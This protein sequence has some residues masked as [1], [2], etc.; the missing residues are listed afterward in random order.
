MTQARTIYVE[1]LPEEV[2][3][4]T[5]I[6]KRIE[7]CLLDTQLVELVKLRVSQIN[8]CSFCVAY[9]STRLRLMD[10]T[11]ER[12][13]QLSVWRESPQF[14]KREQTALQWAEELTRL[15]DC[16]GVSDQRYATTVKEFGDEGI[17]QLTLAVAMINLWNRLGVPFKTDHQFVKQLLEHSAY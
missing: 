14:T 9:H 12:L 6:E 7:A 5:Q 16:N 4:L 3:L 8:G 13:D 10:E 17:A 11:N 1:H 15:A 2:G